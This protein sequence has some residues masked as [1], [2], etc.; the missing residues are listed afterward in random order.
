MATY[1]LK[2]S[3]VRHN[4][5][6]HAIVK[7]EPEDFQKQPEANKWY[8]AAQDEFSLK[9]QNLNEEDTQIIK[10]KDN[11]ALK[12]SLQTSGGIPEVQMFTH[13]KDNVNKISSEMNERKPKSSLAIDKTNIV[14]KEYAV[15][16][17]QGNSK[18]DFLSKNKDSLFQSDNLIQTVSHSRPIDVFNMNF[19]NISKTTESTYESAIDYSPINSTHPLGNALE[20][21]KEVIN[22]QILNGVTDSKPDADTIVIKSSSDDKTSKASP[23]TD[24][25]VEPRTHMNISSSIPT[26]HICQRS[27]GLKK[28]LDQHIRRIHTNQAEGERKLYKCT[29]C[30]KTFISQK[31]MMDHINNF[32]TDLKPFTCSYCPRVLTRISHKRAHENE[33]HLGNRKYVCKICNK[34]FKRNTLLIRHEDSVHK[35]V[36]NFACDRCPIAMSDKRNLQKHIEGVHLKIKPYSCTKCDKTF[37]AKFQLESHF[38]AVHENKQQNIC[39]LCGKSMLF[40]H[41]LRRHILDVHNPIKDTPCPVKASQDAINAIRPFACEAC[42]KKFAK[43]TNLQIHFNYVHNSTYFL[44]DQCDKRFKNK[45]ERNRHINS[46]HLNMRPYACPICDKRFLRKCTIAK[47][48]ENIHKIPRPH[49]CNSCK[50]GDCGRKMPQSRLS[51]KTAITQIVLQSV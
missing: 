18:I 41:T 34:G 29:Q 40:R 19:I 44:C 24:I 10:I 22:I 5:R 39:H 4:N 47:H 31:F 17:L 3:L 11:A 46:I 1:T 2:S 51:E 45:Q 37:F 43:K 49:S 32:H 8:M 35:Q 20:K 16:N 23:I 28:N 21:E 25:T 50:G 30:T 42:D 27:F 36:K 26:C 14:S 6:K 33:V 38:A 48:C 12:N 13:D 15:G 7:A 9:H